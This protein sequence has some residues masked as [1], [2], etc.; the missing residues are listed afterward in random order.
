MC[1]KTII[2]SPPNCTLPS[3]LSELKPDSVFSS[4]AGM[5]GDVAISSTFLRHEGANV[6]ERNRLECFRIL[7]ELNCQINKSYKNGDR[8]Y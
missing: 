7:S 6:L 2:A 5:V 3:A 8:A 1:L 4:K